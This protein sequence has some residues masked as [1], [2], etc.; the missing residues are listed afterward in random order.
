MPLSRF[1]SIWQLSVIFLFRS[2]SFFIDNVVV[3]LLLLFFFNFLFVSSRFGGNCGVRMYFFYAIDGQS[4]QSAF[5]FNIISYISPHYEIFLFKFLF[6]VYLF[7]RERRRESMNR[8][9]AEREGDTESKAGS[10]L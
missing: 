6:N 10:R 3:F 8:G 1:Q 5:E 2:I 7:L 9:G 4:F